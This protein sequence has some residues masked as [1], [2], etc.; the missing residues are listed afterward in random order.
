MGQKLKP[1]M[2][3][4]HR[5]GEK[6]FIDFSGKRPHWVNPQTGDTVDAE[7]F[8]AV[9]GASNYTYAEALPSQQL[10]DWIGAH[11]RMVEFFGGSGRIWVP[12]QLKSGVTVPCRYE[13]GI[14]RT[15]Q[16]AA[17]HYGAVVIPARARKPRDKAKAETHVPIA[18][19]WILARLRNRTFFSLAALNAAIGECLEA[20]NQRPMPQMGASRR[21]LFERLDRPALQ[22]LPAEGYELAAWKIC[23]ANIDYHIEVDRRRLQRPAPVA[24]RATG[25]PLYGHRRRGLLQEPAGGVSS[26]TLR[27]PTL[28]PSRTYAE[29]ASGP[30]PVVP[31]PVNPLGPADRSGRRRAG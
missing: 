12:D 2:R 5:A 29:F 23:R 19:R 10:Q 14:N 3:Q 24:R 18:Q 15:Y 6:V 8:V 9:L 31:V 27:S 26:P 4:A 16:E 11:V 28:D 21:E 25:S 1:S 13:P 30:C 17:Q 22:P 20:L 7:L